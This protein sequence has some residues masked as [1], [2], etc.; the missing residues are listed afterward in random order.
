MRIREF[1]SH[2][3]IISVVIPRVIK[4]LGERVA[5]E[6]ENRPE[7]KGYLGENEHLVIVN[8]NRVKNVMPS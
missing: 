3:Q 4:A 5:E 7:I 2:P 1:F 6:L 8:P